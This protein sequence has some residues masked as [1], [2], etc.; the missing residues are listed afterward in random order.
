MDDVYVVVGLLLFG[1][2]LFCLCCYKVSNLL[3]M[4]YHIDD[5]TGSDDDGLLSLAGLGALGPGAA[6]AAAA[7]AK[8]P[9]GPGRGG[10]DGGPDGGAFGKL[11]D[12]ATTAA[13][14]IMSEYVSNEQLQGNHV[15]NLA[16]SFGAAT[17][18]P[19]AA[20]SA[21]MG[22]G[23]NPVGGN[24]NHYHLQQ[25][26]QQQLQQQQQQ[27]QIQHQRQQQQM[28]QH[29]PQD[30]PGYLRGLRQAESATSLSVGVQVCIK[31]CLLVYIIVLC[32]NLFHN[33]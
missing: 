15:G 3:Y 4:L 20:F 14:L 28:Q 33:R 25:Q 19:S 1:S 26:Q 32:F 6:A 24:P 23:S 13:T 31:H 8:D 27:Q 11:E 7:A 30:P 5:E 18:G 2:L 10:G 21:V 22:N 17:A 12:D 9:F 16:G 29:I